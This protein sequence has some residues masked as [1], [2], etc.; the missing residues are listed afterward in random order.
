LQRSLIQQIKKGLKPGGMIV[1]QNYTMDQMKN[2]QGQSVRRD[3][4]LE[5]GELKKLF[6]DFDILVYSETNDGREAVASLIAKKP[7]NY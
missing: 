2:A 5:K 1:Y 7:L 4:L 6:S 3:Y